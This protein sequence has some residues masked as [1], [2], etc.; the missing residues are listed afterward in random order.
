MQP[1]SR[2]WG[3]ECCNSMGLSSKRRE[4]TQRVNYICVLQVCSEVELNITTTNV[5]DMFPVNTFDVK[6]HCQE[7][8]GIDKRQTN[9]DWPRFIQWIE[10]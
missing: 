5:T 4:E 1:Y 7:K 9:I 6:Q 8:W 3:W 10:S 2:L